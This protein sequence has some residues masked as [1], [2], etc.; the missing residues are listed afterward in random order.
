MEKGILKK[1]QT[2]NSIQ[3]TNHF[4][5]IFSFEI[6]IFV[7]WLVN[8]FQYINNLIYFVCYFYV[9]L[10]LGKSYQFLGIRYLFSCSIFDIYS[11]FDRQFYVVV[12]CT[13]FIPNK[14]INRYQLI[15]YDEIYYC[16]KF[17]RIYF[18]NPVKYVYD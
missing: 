12:C 15:Y 18:N 7:L 5:I 16:I 2:F 1:Y 8:L 6:K 10:K 13:F 17:K 3:Q 4:V 14:A 11:N 9:L